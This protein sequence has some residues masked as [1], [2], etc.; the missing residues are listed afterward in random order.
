MKLKL[1]GFGW[2]PMLHLHSQILSLQFQGQPDV[3]VCHPN[4]PSFV[5]TIPPICARIFFSTCHLHVMASIQSLSRICIG[6]RSQVRL[7]LL[8]LDE[9]DINLTMAIPSKPPLSLRKTA[10]SQVYNSVNQFWMSKSDFDLNASKR[11]NEVHI[12]QSKGIPRCKKSLGLGLH[13]SLWKLI[14]L[15]NQDTSLPPLF[16][17]FLNLW[18]HPN[19]ILK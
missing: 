15:L 2:I 7:N 9:G 19:T 14:S 10:F 16:M 4:Q 5:L 12:L 17:F 11:N 1:H 3:S 13:R 18:F 8:W 6:S